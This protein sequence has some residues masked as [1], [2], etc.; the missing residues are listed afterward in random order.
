MSKNFDL[1]ADQDEPPPKPFEPPNQALAELKIS[2]ASGK[3]SAA[4][5]RFNQL[6][7]S[8]E[9]LRAEIDGVNRALDAQRPAFTAELNRLASLSLDL[10]QQMLGVLD[11]R[12]QTKGL[13]ATQK[14]QAKQIL[15]GLYDQ[16]TGQLDAVALAA[17]APLIARHRSVEDQA[18]LAEE[19]SLALD[20]AKAMFR[21][22]FGKDLPTDESIDT[23]E[24]LMDALAR[25][26][27]REQ[28]ADAEKREARKAKRKPSARAQAAEQQ[29]LDAHGALRTVFRQLASA[30]HPDREVD[31][32][33]RQRKTA[34]MSEVNAAYG[35]RDLSA[36]LRMQLQVAQV[37]AAALGA[38]AEDKVTAMCR[39]LDEQL[40]ALRY[41]RA[42]LG[43]ALQAEFGF[44]AHLLLTEHGLALAMS[45]QIG[46][47]QEQVDAMESDLTAVQDEGSFK[48]WLKSQIRE[49]KAAAREEAAELEFAMMFGPGGP[50]R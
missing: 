5:K 14:R 8:I 11:Q 35:R 30:L 21:E 22:M 20:E 13:T 9:K 46:D 34:L 6:M 19:D 49:M 50:R 43:D 12:L 4:Q 41:D 36:L 15:L 24:D 16:L 47:M 18:A 2:P 31:A 23:P 32:V 42:Q 29:E 7:T 1:F 40:L 37:D 28:A 3:L 27:Q 39:L 10:Q 45:E 26:M 17:L 38:M 44:P 33:E 48:S 25:Q